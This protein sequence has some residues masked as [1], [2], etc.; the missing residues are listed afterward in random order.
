VSGRTNNKNKKNRKWIVV[1]TIL[2]LLYQNPS[3]FAADKDSTQKEANRALK[4]RIDDSNGDP[5]TGKKTPSFDLNDPSNLSKQ[6]EY[7]PVDGNYYFID[8]FT[9]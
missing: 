8:A 1:S 6:I 5:I 2:F 7:D 4:F 3:V 9:A